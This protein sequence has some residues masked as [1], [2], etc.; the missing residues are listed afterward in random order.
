MELKASRVKALQNVKTQTQENMLS[1]YSMFFAEI[2]SKTCRRFS[3][4]SRASA[5]TLLGGPTRNQTGMFNYLKTRSLQQA[6]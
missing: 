4:T 3:L 6:T 2:A 1:S 5:P